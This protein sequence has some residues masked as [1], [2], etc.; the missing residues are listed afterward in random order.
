MLYKESILFDEKYIFPSSI[1]KYTICFTRVI[2]LI[3]KYK[4]YKCDV[5]KNNIYL[6]LYYPNYILEETESIQYQ[7]I[8]NRC[9]A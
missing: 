2:V 3:L 5:N 8:N 1:S 9:T 7:I 4:Q 6:E